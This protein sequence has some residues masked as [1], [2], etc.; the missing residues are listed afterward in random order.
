METRQPYLLSL[1]LQ[2]LQ[3]VLHSFQLLLKLGAFAIKLQIEKRELGDARDWSY[4][5]N[6]LE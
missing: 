2:R 5:G 1:G 3:V 4:N 6:G